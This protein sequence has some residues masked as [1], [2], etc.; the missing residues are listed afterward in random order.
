[1]IR[2]KIQHKR[3]Q[4]VYKL[5]LTNHLACKEG[6]TLIEII[7]SLAIFSVIM[8][9]FSTLMG[10]AIQ[11][12]KNIFQQNRNSM[13]LMKKLALDDP[14]LIRENEEIVIQFE[15][16]KT[17]KIQGQIRSKEEKDVRYKVFVPNE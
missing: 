5:K 13:A 17:L 4:K 6:L 3:A 10:V 14:T 8:M 7:I 11:M 1:M 2:M 12:R 16:G 9:L 15:N